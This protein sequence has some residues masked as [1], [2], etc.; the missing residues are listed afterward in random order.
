MYVYTY[1]HIYIYRKREKTTTVR[2]VQHINCLLVS[3]SLAFS[4]RPSLSLSL[5]P[6]P[7]RAEARHYSHN[8]SLL[9][10]LFFFVVVEEVKGG[11]KD[12]GHVFVFNSYP[13]IFFFFCHMFC[14]SFYFTQR[15]LT[16]KHYKS[17]SQL[18]IDHQKKKKKKRD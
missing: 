18:C 10:S 9:S 7:M 6:H 13:T 16:Y 12:D 4:T 8:Y 17:K 15:K 3:C 11:G 1:I 5:L 2:S 14:I